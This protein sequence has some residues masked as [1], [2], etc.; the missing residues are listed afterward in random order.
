MSLTR[1]IL[2][3]AWLLAA[4]AAQAADP[5]VTPL[6]GE[7][8]ATPRAVRGSDLRQ[9]L[10]YELRLANATDRPMTLGR[11]AVLDRAS[12]AAVLE[13]G[14]DAIGARLAPGGGRGTTSATLGPHQFGV[15]FLH[16]ALAE[17]QPVPAGL[18]HQVDAS[19]EGLGDVP[20]M[21]IAATEVIATPPPVLG[22]PL[23][24]AGYVAGDGCCDSVRHVRALL[25]LGGR[26]YLAQRFAIDW[27]RIDD[28]NRLVV[29]D[30]SDVRSYHIFGDPVFAVADGVVTEARDGLPEQVPG[31]LP[32]GLPIEQADGNY[33]TLDIGGGAF[34]LYAHLRL[35]SVR[36]RAGDRVQRGDQIGEVGNSGNS[37][38]PHL[39]LQVTDSPASLATDGIPYVF[40]AFFVTAVN[41][42]GTADFDR[43]EATGSPMTLTPR[44]PPLRLREVLPLDLSVVEFPGA[45]P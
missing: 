22:P 19:I 11:I 13:M 41:E 28:Q 10:V 27:E 29:G 37:Q 9:H 32:A 45:P 20:G 35:N 24:G 44:S 38:A 18:L 39:H 7:V 33:V 23:R 36:V 6:L 5:P 31:A 21:R 14:P 43:A 2:A 12:G 30:I 17:G 1:R 8:M 4:A 25:P 42:A 26:Q 34:V 3:F 40:D 16:V 15:A